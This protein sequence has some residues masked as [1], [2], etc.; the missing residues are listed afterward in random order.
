[1]PAPHSSTAEIPLTRELLQSISSKGM[2][3]IADDSAVWVDPNQRV[4]AERMWAAKERDRQLIRGMLLESMQR[5]ENGE[6][7]AGRIED[8]L[9]PAG[10]PARKARNLPHTPRS[11]VGSSAV[12][13][14]ART[15]MTRANGLATI[16]AAELNPF[17]SGIKWNLSGAHPKPDTCDSNASRSDEGFPKGVY[18]SNN[19]PEYPEHPNCLCFLTQY[20]ARNIRSIVKELLRRKEGTLRDSPFFIADDIDE[21]NDFARYV[22]GVDADYADDLQIANLTNRAMWEVKEAGFELPSKV[23][24][25]RFTKEL[26][27]SD[28]IYAQ[29]DPNID[30][31]EIN[32]NRKDFFLD[33]RLAR[34]EHD[35]GWFAAQDRIGLIRHEL[36]HTNHFKRSPSM[37]SES[38]DIVPGP[39][40]YGKIT[41]Q[42]SRDGSLD[43]EEF[44]AEVFSG[45]MAGRAY[46]KEVNALYDLFDGPIPKKVKRKI[47][48]DDLER[49]I[50]DFINQPRAAAMPDIS[51]A[52]EDRLVAARKRLKEAQ[53][54]ID[55]NRQRRIERTG[56]AATTDPE[57]VKRIRELVDIITE[58]EAEITLL[59]PRKIKLSPEILAEKERLEN[60]GV[61]KVTFETDLKRLP[62]EAGRE[63]DRHLDDGYAQL[64]ELFIGR[65]EEII[66]A[67]GMVTHPKLGE[68]V[69]RLIAF[70]DTPPQRE[71]WTDPRLAKMYGDTN[72]FA[73]NTWQDTVIHEFGHMKHGD[74]WLENFGVT[75]KDQHHDMVMQILNDVIPGGEDQWADIA[76]KV[77]RRAEYDIYEF[78]AEGYVRLRKGQ[79]LDKDVQRLYDALLGP[80]IKKSRISRAIP[81][82]ETADVLREHYKP[83][84]DDLTK[85]E[86]D[87]LDAWVEGAASQVNDLLRGQPEYLTASYQMLNRWNRNLS[88]SIRRG[89]IPDEITVHRL[90]PTKWLKPDSQLRRLEVG[91][92][93][94]DRGFTATTATDDIQSI[95]PRL[96]ADISD[97]E[98]FIGFRIKVPKD[99]PA[100]YVEDLA[101]GRFKYQKELILHKGGTF[102]VIGKTDNFWE[103]DYIPPKRI[104]RA[105]KDPL[106]VDEQVT[107]GDYTELMHAPVN[108]WLRA[109]KPRNFDDSYG[110]MDDF[111]FTTKDL[112][113]FI[114][115][116]DSAMQESTIDDAVTVFRNTLVDDPRHPLNAGRIGD[117]F[118]DPGFVST[119]KNIDNEVITTGGGQTQTIHVPPG[120]RGI[121]VEINE[122][123]SFPEQEEIILDRNLTFRILNRGDDTI[124]L[125]IVPKRVARATPGF[126]EDEFDDVFLRV[127]SQADELKSLQD[128]FVRSLDADEELV[129]S[130]YTTHTWNAINMHLRDDIPWEMLATAGETP[131]RL[132]QE[133]RILSRI[134]DRASFPDDIVVY[135]HIK[136]PRMRRRLE[137][138]D[139]GGEWRDPGYMST[140]IDP[141]QY[142]DV[143]YVQPDDVFMRINVPR[144]SRAIFF[145]DNLSAHSLEREILI[146]KNSLFRI[147]R[148]DRDNNIWDMTHIPEHKIARAQPDIDLNQ[149]RV[150]QA[151]PLDRN[152][153][154]IKY[155]GLRDAQ[156][157]DYVKLATEKNVLKNITPDIQKAVKSYKGSAYQTVNA[158][159]RGG[160]PEIDRKFID[161]FIF[162]IINKLTPA[163]EMLE[164]PADLRLLRS[165]RTDRGSGNN[166]LQQIFRNPNLGD[167]YIDN[168]FTST[169]VT[170]QAA[171][172][173]KT[174]LGRNAIDLEIH[175]PKGT[176]SLFF[177]QAIDPGEYGELILPRGTVFQ[178]SGVSEDLRRIVLKVVD[179]LKVPNPDPEL[180]YK[181]AI[182]IFEDPRGIT[183]PSVTLNDWAKQI[184]YWDDDL[185][186]IFDSNGLERQP[187]QFTI[188][189]YH[190]IEDN[191]LAKEYSPPFTQEEIILSFKIPDADEQLKETLI[192]MTKNVEEELQEIFPIPEFELGG[193]FNKAT[194]LLQLATDPDS[195]YSIDFNDLEIFL[196]KNMP[197][198]KPF[199]IGEEGIDALLNTNPIISQVWE[200]LDD[201]DTLIHGG[202]ANTH[203]IVQD[204]WGP[205][206]NVQN[207]V[208]AL[209]NVLNRAKWRKLT[210]EDDLTDLENEWASFLD[211]HPDWMTNLHNPLNPTEPPSI[212]DFIAAVIGAGDIDIDNPI[213][214]SAA[215]EL[216][217]KT[218]G[219]D[220]ID[221][222]QQKYFID[223]L[224]VLKSEE[225]LQKLSKKEI[226][227]A[228]ARSE[229]DDLPIFEGKPL[230]AEE[231][232]KQNRRVAAQVREQM[233]LSPEE[234]IRRTLLAAKREEQARL[235][236]LQEGP[237][238]TRPDQELLRRKDL[239]RRLLPS[240]IEAL[241]KL[242]ERKVRGP[243]GVPNIEG[244]PGV[245]E[246]KLGWRE[247][248]IAERAS[249]REY[250]TISAGFKTTKKETRTEYIQRLARSQR[251]GPDTLY[252]N[253]RVPPDQ[254][255]RDAQFKLI[256]KW[257]DR[258]FGP[259]LPAPDKRPRIWE[260]KGGIKLE[261]SIGGPK[262][263]RRKGAPEPSKGGPVI[264]KRGP[265]ITIPKSKQGIV[266]VRPGESN[267][268]KKP[269]FSRFRPIEV[270]RDKKQKTPDI[271]IVPAKKAKAEPSPVAPTAQARPGGV[272]LRD[273]LEGR[274]PPELGTRLK[275]H[276]DDIIKNIKKAGI[277]YEELIKDYPFFP[278][279]SNLGFKD[280]AEITTDILGVKVLEMG[281][282]TAD[283]L[284]GNMLN[285]MNNGI[286]EQIMRGEGFP[287]H[288]N[289]LRAD[290][291]QFNY[292]KRLKPSWLAAFNQIEGNGYVTLVVDHSDYWGSDRLSVNSFIS[293]WHSAPERISSVIHEIG[294]W[295]HWNRDLDFYAELTKDDDWE[296]IAQDFD[297][298]GR[299]S[300]YSAESPR[301]LVAEMYAGRR[302]GRNFDDDLEELYDLL[303]GPR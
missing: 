126:N 71:M 303:G 61:R 7:A 172:T 110:L 282:G 171:S 90:I 155:E 236:K 271:V 51:D 150:A 240:E 168:A 75:Y 289:I 49:Q 43:M 159:L 80:P 174:W 286:F 246:R 229:F 277:D 291:F 38:F 13:T 131:E 297:I 154:I 173:L 132:L 287:D 145:D 292:G 134:F 15:E 201:Y 32:L 135:R 148:V 39:Q 34:L 98:S 2:A 262:I 238:S 63:V 232:K 288:I 151:R 76:G 4:L 30:T 100:G 252:Q 74:R 18:R 222:F 31:I 117:E 78:V 58:A 92:S 192:K 79:I 215:L 114:K 91:D 198:N 19:V 213:I 302:Y 53:K 65:R 142:F 256:D 54:E 295:L 266:I 251:G 177:H 253:L 196:I 272:V 186:K 26:D 73:G 94:I 99:A 190:Q 113:K 300:R 97:D 257:I 176:K 259:M 35:S 83:W 279:T 270:Y 103:V 169:S 69:E 234:S 195:P 227:I 296:L 278:F 55:L 57:E 294:H 128:D 209:A 237:I 290:E 233:R 33:D 122:L 67:Y 267:I 109:G 160:E 203:S 139:E 179:Q 64:D 118:I 144:G 27:G 25:R 107:V 119:S 260:R 299:V 255:A 200:D 23:Q 85:S 77:S 104:A 68:G 112:N 124:E 101:L 136:S 93:I 47:N 212:E 206:S 268:V 36:G 59:R 243:V 235:K 269:L 181:K 46:S 1:M 184:G 106:T 82:D 170:N 123:T 17:V 9:T 228:K 72:F 225:G 10:S 250:D 223:I 84:V 249:R 125:E 157:D 86:R 231:V 275:L 3:E 298:V 163:A 245:P 22:L 52:P 66:D 105:I 121:D 41:S 239:P 24:A 261:P 42:V 230:T 166:P 258:I 116:M 133:E 217:T 89:F 21:A 285:Q 115:H 111:E 8:F 191:L 221:D 137:K 263:I 219:M 189:H 182:K 16:E 138:I 244:L 95:I 247:K 218:K 265:T 248:L 220:I 187:S 88:S 149:H 44:I 183:K 197:E 167:T 50:D 37:Y 108:E 194:T 264:I 56:T 276:P 11:G 175:V 165:I 210:F 70:N 153:D 242:K 188:P 199:M 158:L 48:F 130:N 208:D 281:D 204:L 211:N 301:E 162:K 5:K 178:I 45:R 205:Y 193:D 293:G 147:D 224:E 6:Q 129:I 207:S 280:K 28:S 216:F 140:S 164:M 274:N 120:T 273:I 241:P 156:I 185:D 202:L 254:A 20:V 14:L 152:K 180:A 143:D 29:Y 87:V 96:I 283:I 226:G 284:R 102:R 60:L 161:R 146:D 12:R 127:S 141:T 214:D 81:E 40:Q 62:L